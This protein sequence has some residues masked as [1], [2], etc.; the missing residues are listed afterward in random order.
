MDKSD[1]QTSLTRVKV[2]W[3]KISWTHLAL[4]ETLVDE[5]SVKV[6]APVCP[7]PTHSLHVPITDDA[8]QS[9]VA[10]LELPDV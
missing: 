10:V 8:C 7:L 2:S 5:T 9:P 6:P 1:F 3:A 4:S